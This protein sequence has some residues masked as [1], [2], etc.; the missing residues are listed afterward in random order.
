MNC[1]L[2]RK[3]NLACVIQKKR[4]EVGMGRNGIGIRDNGSKRVVRKVR[5]R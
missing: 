1:R 5:V 2:I 3:Y 4:E